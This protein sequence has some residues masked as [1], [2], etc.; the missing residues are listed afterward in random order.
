[1]ATTRRGLCSLAAL[2]LTGSGGC[3][4]V[5]R[6]EPARFVAPPAPLADGVLEETGYELES[7]EQREETRTFE[8]A[9]QNHEVEVVNRVS[10]YQRS[11]AMGPL[12]EARG[13]V[14]ATLCTPAVSVLGRTFNPVEGMD[15]REIAEE[16]Q[17]QYEELSVGSEIDR[18]TVR[19]LGEGVPLSKFEGEATFRGVGIDV[20]VHVA[21]AEGEEAFVVVF[22]IYPRLLSG[23]EEAIVSLAQGVT[24]DE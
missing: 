18:R 6:G 23:E 9:G 21:L 15:N 11:I 7:M 2:T 1:M 3:L 22:G 5:F 16:T 8:V 24:I 13:A 14:F 20:F 17:S 19:I 10:E 4:D 12:G